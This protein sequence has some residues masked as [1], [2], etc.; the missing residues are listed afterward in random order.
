V[1]EDASADADFFSAP[2][3]RP[4]EALLELRRTLRAVGGLTERGQCFEWKGLSAV[5]LVVDGALLRVQLARR[6]AHSPEW[7]SRTLKDSAAVR[8]F[9]DEVKRRVTR[10]KDADD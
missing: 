9:G 8:K 1:N 4:A 2:P 6:P 10:W 7:E 3:F 5:T